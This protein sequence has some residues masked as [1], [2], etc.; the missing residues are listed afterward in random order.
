MSLQTDLADKEITE[1]K[2]KKLVSAVIIYSFFTRTNKTYAYAFI[3]YVTFLWILLTLY[4][5]ETFYFYM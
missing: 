5:Q 3:Q 2:N 1:N 4:L